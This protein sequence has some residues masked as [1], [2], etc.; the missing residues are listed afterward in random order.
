MGETESWWW[1]LSVCDYKWSRQHSDLVIGKVGRWIFG[2]VSEIR[3]VV[4]EPFWIASAFQPPNESP[5]QSTLWP[6]FADTL[7]FTFFFAVL[8]LESLARWSRRRRRKSRRRGVSR[9]PR[10]AHPNLI[11]PARKVLSDGWR[12][13]NRVKQSGGWKLCF[14]ISMNMFLNLNWLCNSIKRYE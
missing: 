12:W 2:S 4:G 8:C 7:N 6:V 13:S 3:A 5:G 14:S 9:L 1:L 10:P 11:S